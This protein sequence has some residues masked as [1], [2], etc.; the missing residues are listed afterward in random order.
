MEVK[1][2]RSVSGL[3]AA[4][5]KQDD[6]LQLIFKNNETDGCADGVTDFLSSI[7][8]AIANLIAYK[9]LHIIDGKHSG[10]HL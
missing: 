6:L 1:G 4:R 2:L 10:S 9:L 7:N 3:G 5:V 8:G